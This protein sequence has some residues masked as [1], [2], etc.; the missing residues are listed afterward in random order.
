MDVK[1]HRLK[2]AASCSQFNDQGDAAL[3]KRL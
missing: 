3:S 2:G 1:K